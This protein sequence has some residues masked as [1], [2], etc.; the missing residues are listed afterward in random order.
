MLIFFLRLNQQVGP[1]SGSI[2]APE[3]RNFRATILADDEVGRKR[4]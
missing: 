3:I 2:I 1:V 4:F